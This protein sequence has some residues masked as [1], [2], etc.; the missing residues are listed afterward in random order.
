M[1]NSYYKTNV[2][3]L[4]HPSSGKSYFGSLLANS[5]KRPFIDTD[6]LIENLYWQES[7]EKLTCRSIFLHKGEAFFRT[8]EERAIFALENTHHSIIALGG[9]TLLNPHNREKIIKLGHLFYLEVDRLTIKTR[10]LKN[11]IPSF[12]DPSDFENSF[13]KMYATRK[14]IYTSLDAYKVSLES[15]SNDNVLEELVEQV[16]KFD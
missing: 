4:G 9:G 6:R 15:K 5:V 2:I 12:L 16:L 1:Q 11:G 8:L 13:E 3:I 10:M 14:E 7:G